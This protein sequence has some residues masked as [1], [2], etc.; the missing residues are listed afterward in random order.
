[1]TGLDPAAPGAGPGTP[2]AASELSPQAPQAPDAVDHAAGFRRELV[3]RWFAPL[4]G[5]LVPVLLLGFAWSALA[6]RLAFAGW[7]LAAAAGYAVLLRHGVEAGWSRWR[8]VAAL[9]S[10]LALGLAAFAALERRHHEI[11]DLGFRAVLPDLYRPAATRPATALALAVLLA[12][13]AAG[14]VLVA[15]RRAESAVRR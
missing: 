2:S 15:R 8:Q 10:W 1:M 13:V 5:G 9:S 6:D 3:R 7:A 4:A 12:V 11:L 14:S